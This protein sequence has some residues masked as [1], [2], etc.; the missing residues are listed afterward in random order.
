[1]KDRSVFLISL[2]NYALLGLGATLCLSAIEWVDLNIQ[3]T[4]V[5]DSARERLAFS[6]YFSLNLLVGSALGLLVGLAAHAASA[7]K[8]ALQALFARGGRARPRQAV[9]AACA[10]ALFASFLLF[11]Q[12]HIFGYALGL[13]REAEKIYFLRRPLL[14]NETLSAYIVIL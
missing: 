14:A 7:S 8:R 5:F 10:V 13:I 4:P 2:A 12:P 1:M 11:L 6:S 3:L 9:M